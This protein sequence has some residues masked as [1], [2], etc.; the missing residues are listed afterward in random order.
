VD[1][2]EDG[3][4][5]L[6][7]IFCAD[8]EILRWEDGS[9]ANDVVDRQPYHIICAAP[10]PHKH[11][12]R[13]PAEKIVDIQDTTTTLLRQVLMNLYHTNNPR[14]GI[15][16]FGMSENTLDDLLSTRVG[17]ITRFAR[18]PA[19][20]YTPMSVPFTANATFPML[21]YWDKVKRDRTG[22]HSDSEGLSPVD[23]KNIQQSV[24]ASSV[25]MSKQKIE[26]IAR[27]FAETGVK[28]LF[29]HIH[30]LLLKHQDKERL[31]R[32]RNTYVP[33]NPSQ[34]RTREDLTLTVGLGI[35][36]REQNLMH[37]SAIHDLQLQMQ[38]SELKNLTVTPKNFY[39]VASEFVK[40]ANLKDPALFFTDPG[41]QL[42]PPPQDEQQM[43][44]QQQM[45]ME[46]RRQQL[47]AERQQFQ[48]AKLQL[49]QEKLQLL[50]QRELAKVE[51]TSQ[52]RQDDFMVKTEELRNKI[53][54]LQMELQEK[55]M[56]RPLDI[57][58]RTAKV[59]NIN[60]DTRA[61]TA[62]ALKTVGEAEAIDLENDATETGL[63]ELVEN[64]SG[65]E[66]E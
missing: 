14:H 63:T 17:G 22:V 39:N 51:I 25:D 64:M 52:K 23:L 31:V 30:E 24:M 47:D 15:A 37:L 19:E 62:T 26:L 10:L 2:D 45:E 59:R 38:Q 35:G 33:I 13:S 3:L 34:W 50:H 61:K 16:E 28:T 21:E 48:V 40:N 7:Q 66:T 27:L 56:M 9:L 1:A 8:G 57:A 20:V 60:A 41:D 29:A 18:N 54:E 4:S 43:L 42:E 44:E 5:E 49:E 11:Y 6:R 36:T 46:Q 12:G 65:E 58:E 55:E 32:L 53:M